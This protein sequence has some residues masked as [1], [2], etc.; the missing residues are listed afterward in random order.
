MPAALPEPRAEPEPNDRDEVFAT[1]AR[2]VLRQVVPQ[3]AARAQSEIARVLSIAANANEPTQDR[4]VVEAARSMWVADPGTNFAPGIAPADARQLNDEALDAYWSRHNM[5]EAFDL[6]L[7]AFGANPYDAEIAG[8]LALLHLKPNRLQPET[9]RQLALVA[10][11]YRGA[12]PRSGRFEDWTTYAIASALT[13]RAA[14][15]K[16]AFFVTV[17]LSQNI[18]RSCRAAMGAFSNYGER[19]RE[20]V[21]AMFHRIHAQGRAYESPYCS[22]PPRVAMAPRMQ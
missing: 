16:N 21:E 22:W 5:I 3:I 12:R 18:E 6:Q 17:A 14:D 20:P 4:A 10:L 11:V 9:A 8:N 19:L 7:K 2:R 13:G 1:E 15:S